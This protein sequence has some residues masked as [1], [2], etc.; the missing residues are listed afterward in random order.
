MSAILELTWDQIHWPGGREPMD[1]TRALVAAN[2]RVHPFHGVDF[3]DELRPDLEPLRIDLGRGRRNKRRGTGIISRQNGRLYLALKTA[4]ELRE[5][6]CD[7]VISYRGKAVKKI[8]LEPAY[9]RAQLM[10]YKR[11]N[12][13]LK[14]TTCSLLVQA[15]KRFEEVAELVGTR[16]DTIRKHYG[17]L[18]PDHIETAAAVLSF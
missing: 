3:D 7:R 17:H 11:R 10:H 18:S 14:H 12:H 13:I 2:D 8:N 16:A 9:K 1:D 4:W 15:G 6:G 5:L